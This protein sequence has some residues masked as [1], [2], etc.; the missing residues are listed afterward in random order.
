MR[1]RA[2]ERDPI[3]KYLGNSD[4]DFGGEREIKREREKEREIYVFYFGLLH[5][6]INLILIKTG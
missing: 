1:C 6:E 5:L 2:S 3:N 4:L